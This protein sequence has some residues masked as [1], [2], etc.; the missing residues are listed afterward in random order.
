MRSPD[1][2]DWHDKLNLHEAANKLFKDLTEY[3]SGKGIAVL[4]YEKS[5]VSKS[6]GQ[7]KP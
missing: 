5:C 1:K 6:M 7:Y 2:L 3:L 4:K